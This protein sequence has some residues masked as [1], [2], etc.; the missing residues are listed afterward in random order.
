M[1]GAPPIHVISLARTPDRLASFRADNPDL[2]GWEVFPAV[3]G[4]AVDAATRDALGDTSLYSAGAVGNA[5][6]HMAL[7]R[8]CIAG[9]QPLTVCE[10]DA[11]LRGDFAEAGARLLAQ[12]PDYDLVL[13]GWNFD[14]VVEAE[15]SPGV[16]VAMLADQEALRRQAPLFRRDRR[17][18]APLGLRKALGILCYT[19]SPKGAARLAS[20]AVP[21][22]TTRLSMPLMPHDIENA[23]FDVVVA[24]HYMRL[25]AHLS[26]PPLA[27][28]RNEWSRSTVCLAPPLPP[29]EAMARA[30]EHKAAGRTAEAL[31]TLQACAR[32]WPGVAETWARL[33]LTLAEQGLLSAASAA[34]ERVRAI[35]PEDATASYNLARVRLLQGQAKAALDLLDHVVALA[36]DFALAHSNRGVAL[37]ALDR[38]GEAE[39]AFTFAAGLTPDLFEAH[40]GLAAARLAG[41]D[42]AGAADATRAA[43]RLRPEDDA[44]AADL[45][46]LNLHLAKRAEVAGRLDEAVSYARRAADAPGRRL[47]ALVNT[48]DLLERLGAYREAWAA[49]KAATDLDPRSPQAL[50]NLGVA[51]LRLGRPEEAEAAFRAAVSVA[52]DYAD[53]HHGLA[54]ALLK[55]GRWEEGWPEY[56]WRLRTPANAARWQGFDGPPWIGDLQ[57]HARLLLVSEQGLGDTLQAVSLVGEIR[58]RVARVILQVPAPL[59]SLL[60]RAPGVDEVVEDG[61]LRPA[62]DLWL[63]LMSLPGRLDIRADRRPPARAPLVAHPDRVARWRSR[64]PGHGV[65]IGVAWQGNP[66]ARVEPGRSFPLAALQPLARLEGVTLVSLQKGFGSE[67]LQHGRGGLEGFLDLGEA[68]QDGDFEDTAAV[69]ANLDLVVCCDT[70]VAHLAGMLGRPVWIVVGD[71]A[72]WRWPPG[73]QDTPWYSSARIFCRNPDEDWI[74]V[75]RRL[76]ARLVH[77]EEALKAGGAA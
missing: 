18:P 73:S 31:G 75:F 22:P 40:K 50:N 56:E 74:Q 65:R 21:F 77:V 58:P 15:V 13:W 32:A 8:L 60:R 12:A 43:L 48:A 62:H 41:G 6:S 4:T 29:A 25:S 66:T 23:T 47:A 39:R 54:F 52:P 53:A 55:Q 16:P 64:L 1:A 59:T 36:P 26:F 28:T 2:Q 72:D 67:Q 14:A 61:A 71:N 46:D 11:V 45:A 24:S 38:A 42:L 19:V 30:A 17:A 76:A 34:L 27:I 33:G 63:P 10:D 57:P 7:W 9:A 5:L 20:L 37:L 51:C 3:D 35:S 70:A 44:L 49:A 68:Y 69:M